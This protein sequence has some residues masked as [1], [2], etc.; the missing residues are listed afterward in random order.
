MIDEID[1]D[2]KGSRGIKLEV[3]QASKVKVV[4]ALPI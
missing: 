3:V 4:C 1:E 2:V